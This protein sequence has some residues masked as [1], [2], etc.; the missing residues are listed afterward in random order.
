MGFSKIAISQSRLLSQASSL[1]LPSGH[2]GQ[3]LSLSNAACPSMSL[4]WS[5][6]AAAPLGAAVRHIICGFKLFIYFSSR[7]FCPLRFQGSPQTRWRECF[8]V[9]GNFFLSHFFLKTPFPGWISILTSFVSLF[10]FYI[11]SYLLS[12]TMGCLSGCPMS[13]TSI[14][15]LLCGICLAFKCS[16][17]EFVGEK[18]VSLS[19][20]SAI[21]GPPPLSFSIQGSCSPQ[22]HRS[23]PLI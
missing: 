16:F 11:L 13:S 6:W 9:F 22:P 15:K 2:S 5:I 1:R 4:P 7:L 8:L 17:D 3:V 23:I 20:S 14:Q 19:Y 21:L 18:V 10:I 12:K